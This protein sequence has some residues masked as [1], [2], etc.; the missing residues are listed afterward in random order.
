MT[1]VGTNRQATI[2]ERTITRDVVD[3][4]PQILHLIWIGICNVLG[5]SCR[6]EEQKC[7]GDGC[8]VSHLAGLT[9]DQ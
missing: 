7:Q 5:Y 9:R 3:R 8:K 4:Q 1:V 6:D 2:G